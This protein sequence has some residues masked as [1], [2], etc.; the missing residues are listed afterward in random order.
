MTGA[1]AE[2]KLDRHASALLHEQVAQELCH[3]LA[4]R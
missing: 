3:L 4:L 2:V 1:M